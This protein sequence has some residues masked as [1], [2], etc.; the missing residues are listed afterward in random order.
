[1]GDIPTGF[2]VIEIQTASDGTAS[3]LHSAYSSENQAWSKFHT[4]LSFAAVS[5]LPCH[6]AVILDNQGS[7]LGSMQYVHEAVTA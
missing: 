1:M 3:V 2:V 4:I 7:V 6:A 5:E